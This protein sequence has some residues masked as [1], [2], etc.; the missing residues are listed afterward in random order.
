MISIPEFLTIKLAHLHWDS[1]WVYIPRQQA[2]IT[3]WGVF[4]MDNADK[5]TTPDW[6]SLSRPLVCKL[7]Q[8][9]SFHWI[10]Y[11]VVI[12]NK[13]RCPGLYFISK[14]NLS[15]CVICLMIFRIVFVA[16]KDPF[17][18]FLSF[19]KSTLYYLF[20]TYKNNLSIYSSISWTLLKLE[21]YRKA[22]DIPRQKHA[23]MTCILM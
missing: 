18:D 17:H 3:I 6:I 10:S 2:L 9:C 23:F 21:I 8:N 13:L 4:L 15:L 14:M 1:L 7:L 16:S 12:S 5:K 20:I 11:L 22:A 19:R